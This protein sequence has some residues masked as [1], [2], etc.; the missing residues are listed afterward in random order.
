MLRGYTFAH[1]L[2][3][4]VRLYTK[5]GDAETTV[6]AHDLSEELQRCGTETHCILVNGVAV[7]SSF[8]VTNV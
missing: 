5:A 6:A 3:A 7:Y 2:H 1:I 8:E 4:R